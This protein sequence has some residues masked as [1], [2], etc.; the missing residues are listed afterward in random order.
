AEVNKAL[1][2]LDYIHKAKRIVFKKGRKETL[3]VIEEGKAFKVPSIGSS[4]LEVQSIGSF[5][6]VDLDLILN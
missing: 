3:V 6:I 5:S 1:V 4:I 2:K